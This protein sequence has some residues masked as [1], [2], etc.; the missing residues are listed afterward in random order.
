MAIKKPYFSGVSLTVPIGQHNVSFS[1]VPGWVTPSDEIVII[2]RNQTTNLY[3]SYTQRFGD[4]QVNISNNFENIKW[5]FD[6]VEYDN[7]TLVENILIG[8]YWL[9]FPEVAGFNTPA[10]RQIEIIENEIVTINVTYTLKMGAIQCIITGA[11]N[12]AKWNIIDIGNNYDSE[13]TIINLPIGSYTLSFTSVEGWVTPAQMEVIVTN[14][15]T[16]IVHI[17]YEEIV[18]VAYEPLF[19]WGNLGADIELPPIGSLQVNIIGGGENVY[20]QIDGYGSEYQ[21]GETIDLFASEDYNYRITV[22]YITGWI[23]PENSY[24]FII[25][26]ETIIL[27][28]TYEIM[29]PGQLQVFLFDDDGK[30]RWNRPY[31][32][33]DLVSGTI[34]DMEPGT[35]NEL[36]F[37]SLS[38]NYI[39][40]ISEYAPFTITP[41]Q[42]TVLNATYRQGYNSGTI[43]VFISG[44]DGLGR[45]TINWGSYENISG[46]KVHLST[47]NKTLRFKSIDGYDLPSQHNTSINIISGQT[48][49][50]NAVYAKAVRGR[51]QVFAPEVAS[52]SS[53]IWYINGISMSTQASGNIYSVVPGTYEIRF[54]QITNWIEPAY[55]TVTVAADELVSITVHYNPYTLFGWGASESRQLSPNNSNTIVSSITGVRFVPPSPIKDMYIADVQTT[56]VLEN[57]EIYTWGNTGV[58]AVSQVQKINFIFPDTIKKIYTDFSQNL[59]VA[60]LNNEN[61]YIWGGNSYGLFGNNTTTS[62]ITP[63]LLNYTFPANIK[64][65]RI[66]YNYIV[67]L[68]E[69]NEIYHWGSNVSLLVPTKLNTPFVDPIK[70]IYLTY[71]STLFVLLENG[72]VYGKGN[73]ALY[74]LCYYYTRNYF[75]Y[76]EILSALSINEIYVGP[77]HCYAKTNSNELYAWG[78]NKP[79][80]TGAENAGALGIGVT[81]SDSCIP[82]KFEFDFPSNI[83][84]IILGRDFTYAILE[85][86]DIYVWGHNTNGA[87]LRTACNTPQKININITNAVNYTFKNPMSNLKFGQRTIFAIV[88]EE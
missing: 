69:N 79:S 44:E 23:K 52:I 27:N 32:S 11:N 64:N 19:W 86:D 22:P 36:N 6:N 81:H 53:S 45:W 51:I 54:L 77:Y 72:N 50:V 9:V 13:D 24:V 41:N 1:D 76:S 58:S 26:N 14:N 37:K 87:L 16:T 5:Q 33:A 3:V 61:I 4:I 30:G 65:I 78:R 56:A 8:T 62:S 85:N 15:Q 57:N 73:A 49:V 88:D 20:W 47:G 7:N 59:T 28:I 43:Q 75:S 67:V 34:I 84:K 21:S 2:R 18:I 66:S 74:G 80:V 83:Q 38:N 82:R 31:Y 60:L 48:V 25:E 29:I 70:D 17:E 12:L 40:S 71:E 55:Y 63:T 39:P 46:A 42:L 10:M 68:L 35:Y